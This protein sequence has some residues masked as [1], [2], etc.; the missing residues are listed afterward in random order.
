MQLD[1]IRLHFSMIE[2]YQGL[3]EGE[4]FMT[5][6]EQNLT[7][8]FQVKDSILGVIK[9]N[10]KTLR[11]PLRVISDVRYIRNMF[12][13]RIRFSVNDLELL[14]SFPGA[15]KGTIKVKIRRRDKEMAE[16]LAAYLQGRPVEKRLDNV[17][18]HDPFLGT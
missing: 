5:V 9:S 8:D 1:D 17:T 11:I 3:A 12:M 18:Y 10:P 7:M 15:N 16:V 6:D 4:G 2:V 13:S 14:N